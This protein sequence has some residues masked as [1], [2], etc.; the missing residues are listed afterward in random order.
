MLLDLLPH[1]SR[2]A[3]R[4]TAGRWAGP[5]SLV[6]I[7]PLRL[8]HLSSRLAYK[9]HQLPAAQTRPSPRHRLQSSNS[10][11]PHQVLVTVYFSWTATLLFGHPREALWFCFQSHCKPQLFFPDQYVHFKVKSKRQAGFS[12]IN[13][14]KGS[15]PL[16]WATAP[17][18]SELFRTP[19]GEKPPPPPRKEYI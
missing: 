9:L 10:S 19:L 12:L 2:A 5:Q 17:K 15:L 6:R 3:Q 11:I 18:T 13:V 16:C 14:Y 4:R 8:L 1:G 7:P